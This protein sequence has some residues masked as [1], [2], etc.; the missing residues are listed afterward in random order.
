[1]EGLTFKVTPERGS[2]DHSNTLSFV[3][4]APNYTFDS[5]K[6][7]KY[8]LTAMDEDFNIIMGSE[9]DEL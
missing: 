1:M 9:L 3:Y 5:K 7:E 2:Y 8:R 4:E 6:A